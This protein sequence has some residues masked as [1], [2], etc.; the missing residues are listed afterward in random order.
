MQREVTCIYKMQGSCLG[1]SMYDR[2]LSWRLDVSLDGA[3]WIAPWIRSIAVIAFAA[4]ATPAPAY[5]P[6]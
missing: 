5:A 4:L 1:S 2:V 6:T 3:A